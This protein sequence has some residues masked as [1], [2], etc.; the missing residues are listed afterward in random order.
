MG[1]IGVTSATN[2]EGGRDLPA[3]GCESPFME[4][5]VEVI[6]T[7][8]HMKIPTRWKAMSTVLVWLAIAGMSAGTTGSARTSAQKAV[9]EP[10]QPEVVTRTFD[11]DCS[12]IFFDA[13]RLVLREASDV[14]THARNAGCVSRFDRVDFSQET[15]IAV[16]L[17]TGWCRLPVGLRYRTL[18]DDTRRRYVLEVRYPVPKEPCRAQSRYELWI[19]V[20][21]LP[22]GYTVDFDIFG[23]EMSAGIQ[24]SCNEAKGVASFRESTSVLRDPLS[25]RPPIPGAIPSHP[26]AMHSRPLEITEPRAVASRPRGCRPHELFDIRESPIVGVLQTTDTSSK[27]T[28]TDYLDGAG[29]RPLMLFVRHLQYAV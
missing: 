1:G 18:R 13:D 19:A 2:T 20:P 6:A 27:C 26:N 11:S 29:S 10:R 9:E 8:K 28:S 3:R 21:A 14:R 16:V 25:T 22:Q 23:D 17:S 7:R 24:P 5:A 12:L 4:A 15:V